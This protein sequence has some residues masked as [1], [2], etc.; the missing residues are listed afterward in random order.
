[1][2][3]TRLSQATMG[4]GS[5]QSFGGRHHRTG[6]SARHATD[7]RSC[8]HGQLASIGRACPNLRSLRMEGI[9]RA[10]EDLIRAMFAA[11]GQ[12]LPGIIELQLE[13]DLDVY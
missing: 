3:V 1:M 10:Q 7:R 11:I 4:H 12:H 8:R 5:M 2:M 9:H 13:L 6:G